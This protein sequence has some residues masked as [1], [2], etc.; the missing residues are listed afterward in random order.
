MFGERFLRGDCRKSGGQRRSVCEQNERKGTIARH[1]RYAFRELH[2]ATERAAIFLRE[3]R[4]DDALQADRKRRIFQLL[5]GVDGKISAP[6][7]QNYGN[8]EHKQTSALLSGMRR[9]KNRF[10]KRGGV[11][12]C[13]D[14]FA[15]RHETRFG[16]DRRR[17]EQSPFRRRERNVRLRV[18]ELCFENRSGRK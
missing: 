7:R 8:Y 11:L 2:G 14:G 6:E 12:P 4:F 10:Y 3:R 17:H 18:C 15:R 9:R 1:E 16:G 13:G 5:Q